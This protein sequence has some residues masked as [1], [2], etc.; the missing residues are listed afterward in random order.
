MKP[1]KISELSCDAIDMQPLDADW[2]EGYGE[3]WEYYEASACEKCGVLVV[4]RGDERHFDIDD[5][6]ECDGHVPLAEGPMMNYFYP[7]SGSVD[8]YESAL[9]IADLP[10]CIVDRDMNGDV[11]LALTGG[12]MDL[13]WEICEAFMRLGHLPPAHFADLP[14]MAGRG[15]SARDRWIVRGCLATLKVQADWAKRKEAR[16][17]ETVKQL[18]KREAERKEERKVG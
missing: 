14:G 18:R 7:L 6:T 8:Y 17:R 3:T 13:S 1:T 5:R 15:S 4:S 2:S 16:L 10:L 9:K 11:G 12:G